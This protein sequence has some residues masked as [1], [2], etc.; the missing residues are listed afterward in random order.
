MDVQHIG[1]RHIPDQNCD[2]CASLIVLNSFFFFNV[3]LNHTING[4]AELGCCQQDDSESHA[5]IDLLKCIQISLAY[6]FNWNKPQFELSST[7][8]ADLRFFFFFLLN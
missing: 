2:M 5:V 3:L 4:N 6:Y 7:L 1:T 8:K